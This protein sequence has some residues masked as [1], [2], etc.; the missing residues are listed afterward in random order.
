MTEPHKKNRPKSS[1]FQR[2]TEAVSNYLK[3]QE[4]QQKHD[5]LDKITSGSTGPLVPRPGEFAVFSRTLH[6]NPTREMLLSEF[7]QTGLLSATMMTQRSVPNMQISRPTFSR[8]SSRG[9]LNTNRGLVSRE[10]AK[11]S[12]ERSEEGP[13]EII[14][15]TQLRNITKHQI[16]HLLTSSSVAMLNEDTLTRPDSRLSSLFSSS[17]PTTAGIIRKSGIA[18]VLD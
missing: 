17:R 8:E 6:E 11:N 2:H 10:S 14:L 5:V 13:G 3:F 1:R 7:V 4:L 16:P 9:N 15:T 18:P 12:P